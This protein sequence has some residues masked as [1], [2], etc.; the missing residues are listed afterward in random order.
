M[1]CALGDRGKRAGGSSRLC[2]H[3]VLTSLR[4]RQRSEASLLQIDLVRFLSVVAAATD[5]KLLTPKTKD[6]VSRIFASWNQLDRWL[7]QIAEL[8]AA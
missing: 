6:V 4:T 5:G 3:A 7:R 2:R 1:R 8:R